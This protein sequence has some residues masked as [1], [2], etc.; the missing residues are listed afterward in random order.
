MSVINTKIEDGVGILTWTDTERPMNVMSES[1]LLE[2][3]AAIVQLF[4]N[5]AVKGV[6]ITSGKKEFIVGAD[7]SMVTR[8]RESSKEHAFS[9]IQRL[10][11]MLRDLE[12][13]KK[14]SGG[15]GQW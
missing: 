9:Q 2:F 3:D 10:S 7:I 14:T 4:A 8:L 11:F 15:C 1:V 6:V 5:P 13:Q 12:K